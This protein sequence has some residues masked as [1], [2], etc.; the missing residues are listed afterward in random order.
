MTPSLLVTSS[1]PGEGK[2]IT[3]ANL[4]VV[5]AQS[6]RQVL[7]G[8][9]A[10]ATPRAQQWTDAGIVHDSILAPTRWRPGLLIGEHVTAP[11]AARA[12]PTT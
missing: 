5:F 8:Q 10:I 12:L 11:G 9:P 6:G 4:A 3:A 2:T 1:V 7:L